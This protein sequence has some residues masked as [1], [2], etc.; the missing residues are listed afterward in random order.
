[1]Y[2]HKIDCIKKSGIKKQTWTKPKTDVTHENE[3]KPNIFRNLLGSGQ[4]VDL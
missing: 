2:V 3:P 1:M 4:E